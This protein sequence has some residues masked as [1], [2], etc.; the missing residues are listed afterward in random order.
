MKNLAQHALLLLAMAGFGCDSRNKEE[1][2]PDGL[3]QNAAMNESVETSGNH[4]HF[5]LQ[6]IRNGD[7]TQRRGDYKYRILSGKEIHVIAS[8]NDSTFVFGIM[9]Y[10][11]LWDG[12]SILRKERDSS[13]ITVFSKT[14][15]P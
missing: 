10:V 1:R 5:L 7:I 4:I 11:W 14:A 9:S 2:I 3:Y 8:S 6:T 15:A 12:E 13:E